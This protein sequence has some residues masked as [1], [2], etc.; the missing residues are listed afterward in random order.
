[1]FVYKFHG[2]LIIS[3]K[4]VFTSGVTFRNI[5]Y[6]YSLWTFFLWDFIDQNVDF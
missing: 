4:V 2:V 3:G 5:L 6:F 1:M